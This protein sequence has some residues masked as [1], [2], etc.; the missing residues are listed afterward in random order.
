[1]A[2]VY[3]SLYQKVE[4]DERTSDGD[5]CE[6]DGE[7]RSIGVVKAA[8]D[9]RKR[10]NKHG[11]REKNADQ[12]EDDRVE[13]VVGVVDRP[14]DDAV[15]DYR[16]PIIES[17][18]AIAEVEGVFPIVDTCTTDALTK[19]SM[20]CDIV[21]IVVIVVCVVVA[22]GALFAFLHAIGVHVI[23]VVAIGAS[24]SSIV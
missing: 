23:V 8:Y 18:C 7:S 14:Q 1:M 21:V 17:R 6:K 5:E 20:D 19:R 9:Q 15:G 22:T 10:R 13:E 2:V 4:Q 11:K 16:S 24:L 3:A 12:V